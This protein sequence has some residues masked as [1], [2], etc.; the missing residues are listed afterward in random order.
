MGGTC[1]TISYSDE[2]AA[3]A[4]LG[5][6]F[7]LVVLLTVL[8]ILKIFYIDTGE[9]IAFSVAAYTNPEVVVTAGA[10]ND[11]LPTP[12]AA[13]E[14]GRRAMTSIYYGTNTTNK[15]KTRSTKTRATM[16]PIGSNKYV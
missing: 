9:Q 15:G 12:A 5:I 11:D 16:P 7:A 8:H 4:V 6:Q 3:K 1:P 2:N 13:S 10:S 14:K